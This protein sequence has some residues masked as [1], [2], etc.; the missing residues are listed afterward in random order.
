MS[1][2]LRCPKS[3]TET[4]SPRNG[5]ALLIGF[6]D[7][8]QLFSPVPDNSH[9]LATSV[10]AVKSFRNALGSPCEPKPNHASLLN[11]MYGPV[12]KTDSAA[13]NFAISEVR[14]AA[15]APSNRLDVTSFRARKSKYGINPIP[16]ILVVS[17][18]YGSVE[19]CCFGSV[20]T[21]SADPPN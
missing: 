8:N 2:R 11:C 18:S 14:I 16:L 21:E 20:I 7:L 17:L 19:Y 1:S 6:F 9:L 5:V 15:L 12:S 13:Y 10:S 4:R 3:T